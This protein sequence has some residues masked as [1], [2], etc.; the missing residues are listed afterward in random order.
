MH[1]IFEELRDALQLVVVD[2]GAGGDKY[3]I[4]IDERI[5]NKDKC[6]PLKIDADFIWKIDKLAERKND[7][8]IFSDYFNIRDERYKM[9]L[10]CQW[11]FG[12]GKDVKICLLIYADE[13]D[14]D[15]RWP[16]ERGVT[17]S[18]TN[19]DMPQVRKAVTNQ[20][21]IV[22]PSNNCYQQSSAFKFSYIDLSNE[23]LLLGNNMIVNCAIDTQ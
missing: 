20:C 23:G 14:A 11:R 16:F 7:T 21:R 2:I 17:V 1:A 15:L 12:A 13:T 9:R 3:K 6:L 4:A 18:I 10:Y 8:Y 22:K 19:Q 5:S